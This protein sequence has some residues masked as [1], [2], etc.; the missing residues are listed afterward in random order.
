MTGRCPECGAQFERRADWQR[1]CWECW[2][3]KKDREVS[4]TAWERGYDAGFTDGLAAGRRGPRES[5]D[6][7]R[8]AVLLCHPDR[9][10]PERFEIANQITARLLEMLEQR[11]GVA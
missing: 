6:F 5:A 7:I 8:T 4:A 2:R 3:A 10:P 9:H 11:K 1:L